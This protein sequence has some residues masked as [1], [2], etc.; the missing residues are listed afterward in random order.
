MDNTITRGIADVLQRVYGDATQTVLDHRA[1]REVWEYLLSRGVAE[2][3]T[4]AALIAAAGGEIRV[5]ESLLLDPPQEV[6]TW[7]VMDPPEHVYRVV[8]RTLAAAEAIAPG[9]A[10]EYTPD[11]SGRVR[12][13]DGARKQLR[14]STDPRDPNRA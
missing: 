5:S 8:S 7:R 12:R 4:V 9:D 10:V 3:S 6:K 13:T 14:L 1:A 2:H 11:D